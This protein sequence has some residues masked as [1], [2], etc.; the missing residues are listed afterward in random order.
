MRSLDRL[1]SSGRLDSWESVLGQRACVF[2]SLF[3]WCENLLEQPMAADSG[4]D[5]VCFTDDPDLKR[6]S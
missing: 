3:G 5:L 4:I 1:G 6:E 2:T